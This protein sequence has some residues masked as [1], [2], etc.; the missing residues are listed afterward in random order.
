MRLIVQQVG[1]AIR[2][3]LPQPVNGEFTSVADET[4]YTTTTPE[5]WN[6][7]LGQGES[8]LCL[9]SRPTQTQSTPTLEEQRTTNERTTQSLS[10]VLAVAGSG[11]NRVVV[12]AMAGTVG[13]DVPQVSNHYTPMQTGT[14][15]P[16][17][18]SDVRHYAAK[19]PSEENSS[20][21]SRINITQS[22]SPVP[23][24][25]G[26][27]D[28]SVMG[29]TSA[30]TVGQIVPQASSHVHHKSVEVTA[31]S[32]FFTAGRSTHT[33]GTRSSSVSSASPTIRSTLDSH[34][35]GCFALQWNLRGLRANISE[36]K[37]LITDLEPC[38]I[39]LQ[40]TKVN[41]IVAPPNFLGSN[42]T[43]LLESNNV[44]YWQHGGNFN[45]HDLACGSLSSTVLTLDKELVILNNGSPTR[46]DPVTG[47]TSAIDL[48]LCSAR[49]AGRFTWRTLSDTH[50]NDHFPIAM[51]IPGWSCFRIA[52]QKWLYDRADWPLYEC[53]TAQT[54]RPDV[55]WNVESFTE[56]IIAAAT[57]AIPRSSGREARAVARKV[58]KQAKEQSWE[59]FVERITP[60]STT[61]ELWRTVNTLRGSRQQRSVV[62][63]SADGFTNN[64]EEVAEELAEYYSKRSATSSYPLFFQKAKVVAERKPINYSPNTDDVYNADISLNEL[65]WA[66][67]KGR[68]TSTGPDSVGYPLLQRLPPSVKIILLELLNKIW[69]EGEFPTSWR[70]AIIV[71]IP[72]SNC[73]DSGPAAFRPISL[74]SCMAKLFERII[75]RRLI[76]ELES[77][78]R[79]DKRQHAFRAGRGADSY[80]AELEKYLPTADEHAL[81]A[82]LDLSKAYDTTWKYGILR[83]LKSWRIRG[84]MINLLKSFLTKRTFQVSVERHLSREHPLENGVPQGSVLSVTLFL[85]AMQPIF[86]VIPTKVNILLYADDILLVVHGKKNEGLHR[87]LHA[88]VNAVN[89]WARSVGFTI[90]PSKSHIFYCSPNARREPSSQISID[91]V[92]IPRTNRLR[93]LGVTLD[94]TLTF[95]PHCR[96]VKEA[97]ESR[98][99]ILQMIGA[100]L[101]RGNR[102]SLLQVG[103]ALVTAKLIYGIG[104][105]SRAGPST[106]QTLAPAYNKMVRYASGAFVTSPINSVMAEAGTLPFELLATQATA[107]TAIRLQ[108]KNTSHATALTQR[109][110]DRL[111]ELTDSSLP[112]VGQQ[113]RLSDRVWHAR[114][115]VVLWDVKRKVRAGDPPE[116]VQ[117]IVR[118]LLETRFNR[119]TVVYTDGSKDSNG[120]TVGA[121]FFN[122]GITGTYS[123][124]KECS[125]FS[126]EA[127]ALKMAAAIRKFNNEL[128]ILTDSASC[129]MALE[130]GK[131]RHPWIQ[132][133]E[134]IAQSKPIRFCWIPGH[135]GVNGNSE[136]E[137]LAYEARRPEPSMLRSLLRMRLKPLKKQ[138][139]VNGITNGLT[140]ENRS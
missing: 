3:D 61:T 22:I 56:K 80:F 76:T 98:L 137:R 34:T 26:I 4:G 41:Q 69:S 92:P 68:S 88:A 130:T 9:C 79:L 101:P 106:L 55:E 87:K 49:L 121:A 2:D 35:D 138:Y 15:L 117:P 126:A 128:V 70:N 99:R 86:R 140:A 39:A 30:G 115:P 100:K 94:R 44:H 103:S 42:Y 1:G 105:V 63:K 83:S 118:Q 90:S 135:A 109:T 111:L 136:A 102:L 116:K 47:N 127:Y 10:T 129:L 38:V 85:I 29:S 74:T 5:T 24:V 16:N 46:I 64:P 57:R 50:N 60:S 37:L 21:T 52:R 51:F 81:V 124:P 53:I 18:L 139:A 45:A 7:R 75:N 114:K 20:R 17:T 48:T 93:I 32:S 25:V 58:V 65:L 73:S 132:E 62:I 95:K 113:D 84:R 23:V 91:R 72:K 78:G 71:P 11:N 119:S 33:A 12:S 31:A 8:P 54:I 133:V 14:A 89:K 82:S 59:K 36:L 120:S 110:S 134:R 112:A 13:Q 123:L 43:L 66:L 6:R 27:G 125:V 122:N 108:S 19:L 104:L 67:D 96:N 107:R 28:T 97:C 40:E 77:T 131:S